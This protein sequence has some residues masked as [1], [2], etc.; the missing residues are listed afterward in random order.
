MTKQTRRA[1]EDENTK[2]RASLLTKDAQMAKLKRKYDRLAVRYRELQDSFRA[3]RTTEVEAGDQAKQSFEK[4]QEIKAGAEPLLFA[5]GWRKDDE[6]PQ[7]PNPF[8]PHTPLRRRYCD[9]QTGLYFSFHDAVRIAFG[10]D[11]RHAGIPK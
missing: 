5:E 1:L 4:F 2:L 10:T 9:P 3:L 11:P 8:D 7:V 6:G